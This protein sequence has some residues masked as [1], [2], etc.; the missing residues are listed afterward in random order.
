MMK[1][2]FSPFTMGLLFVMGVAFSAALVNG[3]TTAP[4]AGAPTP[5]VAQQYIAAATLTVKLVDQVTLA[6]DAALKQGWL[7]GQDAK[8]VQTILNAANNGLIAA[9][10]AASTDPGSALTAVTALSAGLAGAA[11]IIAGVKPKPPAPATAG[12][13]S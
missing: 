10:A 12:G 2:L 4:V 6:A 3:C 9:K 13:T 1:R 7:K 8:N 11:A 5:T